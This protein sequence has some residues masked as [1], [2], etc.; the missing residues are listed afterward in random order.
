MQT[1]D[2]K[3]SPILHRKNAFLPSEF[4]AELQETRETEATEAGTITVEEAFKVSETEKAG[5]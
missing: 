4:E 3:P 1:K 5:R 2:T